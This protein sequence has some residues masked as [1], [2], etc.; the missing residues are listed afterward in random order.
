MIQNK[1]ITKIE[2]YSYNIREEKFRN[3]VIYRTR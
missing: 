3:V 2:G 1:K